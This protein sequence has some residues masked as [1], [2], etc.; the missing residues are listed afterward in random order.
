MCM[1]LVVTPGRVSGRAGAARGAARGREPVLRSP[2]RVAQDTPA[3][4]RGRVSEV[5]LG[6]VSSGG[7]SDNK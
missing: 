2:L 5:A 6:H 7:D 3:K 1:R 4:G